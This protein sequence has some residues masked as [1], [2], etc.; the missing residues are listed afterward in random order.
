MP[1]NQISE[2]WGE[3]GARSSAVSLNPKPSVMPVCRHGTPTDLTTNPN[4]PP[5]S[6]NSPALLAHQPP[7]RPKSPAPHT[8]FSGPPPKILSRSPIGPRSR[9][10]AIPV[11]RSRSR[12][13]VGPDPGRAI[14]VAVPGRA[15]PVGRSRSAVGRSRSAVGRS[16]A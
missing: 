3:Q 16:Q 8:Q 4:I 2:N 11:G 15:T 9:G 5:L 7:D 12:S 1:T 6:P 13:P 10:R 14:P